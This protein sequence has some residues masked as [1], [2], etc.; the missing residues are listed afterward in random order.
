MGLLGLFRRRR[1]REV[2]EFLRPTEL[3][4][5]PPLTPRGPR[6]EVVYDDDDRRAIQYVRNM[7]ARNIW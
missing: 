6:E 3:P 7:T 2:P 5:Q 4:P 1:E